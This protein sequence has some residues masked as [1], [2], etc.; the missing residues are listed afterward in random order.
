[1]KRADLRRH[2]FL[3][4][5][6]L[7][8]LI[9]AGVAGGLAWRGW[10]R[11]GPPGA[12]VE[13]AR[14]EIA[15][16]IRTTAPPSAADANAERGA[17]TGPGEAAGQAVRAHSRTAVRSTGSVSASR[18]L[19]DPSTGLVFSVYFKAV[20]ATLV[21][22]AALMSASVPAQELP[23][24]FVLTREGT[25]DALLLPPDTPPVLRSLA[26]RILGAAG[27]F[28][29]FPASIR[30]ASISFDVLFRFDENVLG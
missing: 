12:S 24:H 13:D 9:H 14:R 17:V 19:E 18:V 21:R 8:L 29:P 15:V 10:F 28:P 7:S 2:P 16:T 23:V 25:V 26:E 20:K 4:A 27:P 3:A 22:Q 1:M 30:H 6:G 5:C 11:A